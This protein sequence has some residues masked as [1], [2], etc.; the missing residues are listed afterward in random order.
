[1]ARLVTY[2][3]PDCGGRFEFMHHPSDEPPPDACLLCNASFDEEPERAVPTRVNIATERQKVPD[4]L[5]R[6]MEEGSRVRSQLAAE[7]CGAHESDMT[8]LKITNMSDNAREGESVAKLDTARAEK[9]LGM[10]GGKPQ[11]MGGAT[12]EMK[13]AQ[14]TEY[15]GMTTAGPAALSTR[16]FIEKTSDSAQAKISQM[17]RAGNDGNAY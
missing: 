6:D 3:C 13:Q 2:Q 5:Y 14:A 11:L 4:K 16:S 7:M 12:M 8:N 1:M 17:T 15:S 9:N 10:M